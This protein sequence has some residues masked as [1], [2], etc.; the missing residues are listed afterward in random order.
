M[1]KHTLCDYKTIKNAVAGEQW[2]LEK[3]L[4]CY[5]EEINTF[6]SIKQKQPDGSIKTI[7]DE[8]MRQHI[9]MKLLEAIA[10]FPLEENEKR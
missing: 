3:V 9:I 1:N 4:E 6:A 10:Q 5:K 2:A 7:I 8:D